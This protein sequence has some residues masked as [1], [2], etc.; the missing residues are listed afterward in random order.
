MKTSRL[1]VAAAA[2]AWLSLSDCSA[3]W[4]TGI[5]AVAPGTNIINAEVTNTLKY[6]TP[7]D[8]GRAG[9]CSVMVSCATESTTTSNGV[10]VAAFKVSPDGTNWFDTA[11]P[12]RISLTLNSTNIVWG[13]AEFDCST[14]QYIKMSGF[15][16]S[17]SN[18]LVPCS[19]T[20]FIK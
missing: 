12:T 14:F 17:T 5:T 16:N 18:R 3:Q 15:E 20:Y 4:L 19:C 1:I 10:P 9:K 11:T 13:W 6:A 8:T 7:Y 2:L